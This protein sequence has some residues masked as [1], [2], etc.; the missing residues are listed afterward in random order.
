MI[1]KDTLIVDVFFLGNLGTNQDPFADF[2]TLTSSLSN[3]NLLAGQPM[4]ASLPMKSPQPMGA[5]KPMGVSTPM[6]AHPTSF[7]G[8]MAAKPTPAAKTPNNL[9]GGLL[10]Y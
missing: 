8:S 4:G 5:S 1:I 3:Q 7:L 9:L 10:L 6:G 2:S